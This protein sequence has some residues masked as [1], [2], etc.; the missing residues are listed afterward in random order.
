[1][2]QSSKK[3]NL[4]LG[5]FL[6]VFGFI[7]LLVGISDANTMESCIS[8]P[9]NFAIWTIG[10]GLEYTGLAL[11]S[12]GIFTLVYSRLQ[13]KGTAR[14]PKYIGYCM[15]ALGLYLGLFGTMYAF[16]WNNN[17]AQTFY[18]QFIGGP[19]LF[20]VGSQSLVTNYAINEI[21]GAILLWGIS[22]ALAGVLSHRKNLA[23][24]IT[25]MK[26]PNLNS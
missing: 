8:I 23:K 16:Y 18:F 25:P 17:S 12:L 7:V 21:G 14:I 13:N 1:V 20:S 2:S 3:R 24:N 19:P 9:C 5:L 15:I 10:L 11:T 22:F 4:A 26:P 6:L